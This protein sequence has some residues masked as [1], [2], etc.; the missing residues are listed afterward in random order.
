MII[1]G[2]NEEVKTTTRWRCSCGVKSSDQCPRA[3]SSRIMIGLPSKQPRGQ[4]KAQE[5]STLH[6]EPQSTR[7]CWEWE[8]QSSPGMKTPTIQHQE[9]S[10]EN[11]YTSNIIQ[12]KQGIFRNTNVYAYMHVIT[13]NGKESWILKKPRN[14]IWKDL[15][16]GKGRENYVIIL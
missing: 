6:K 11:I 5:A 4:E 12:T 1:M 3:W 8:K 16:R 15:E 10:P 13:I 14:G 7:E 9:I 2:K